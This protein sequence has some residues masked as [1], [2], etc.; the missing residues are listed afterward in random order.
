M[1]QHKLYL[2]GVKY[3]VAYAANKW[4]WVHVS[5]RIWL[6]KTHVKLSYGY[7]LQI[8]AIQWLHRNVE[9]KS[10]QR[11]Q[12]APDLHGHLSPFN[13]KK[14]PS[15]LCSDIYF[16]MLVWCVSTLSRVSGFST[17]WRDYGECWCDRGDTVGCYHYPDSW[18]PF[19]NLIVFIPSSCGRS[20]RSV[21]AS[22]C[23]LTWQECERNCPDIT[24]LNSL[25]GLCL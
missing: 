14:L 9:R 11:R 5:C 20:Y 12:T 8:A 15:Y 22:K 19:S 13:H 17:L 24:I 25:F 3:K 21:F 2:D 4:K 16:P 10:T 23:S 1:L 6:S 7:L 18:S